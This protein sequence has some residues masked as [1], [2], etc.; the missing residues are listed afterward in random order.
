MATNFDLSS[1]YFSMSQTP[2]QVKKEM[3]P[4][5]FVQGALTK[6][7]DIFDRLTGR[8]WKPGSSL[9]TSELV[10]RLKS[11]MDAEAKTDAAGRKFVPHNIKLKM[12]WDKFSTDEEMSLK[13]LENELLTAAVDHIN[14]R[15]YYTYAP[16]SIG[17]KQDYFTEGVKLLV[18][19]DKGSG[20]ETERGVDV[21]VPDQNSAIAP[22]TIDTAPSVKQQ[23]TSRIRYQLNGVPR[24]A[25]ADLV[26]GKRL[27]IGRTKEND[28]AIDD[29]SISKYHAAIVLNGD[30]KVVVA[31]TGSTNGTFVADE[32]IAYGKAVEIGSGGAV[33]FGVVVVTI[34]IADV[35]VPEAE[36]QSEKPA[37]TEVYKVGEFEFAKKTSA[38]IPMTTDRSAKTEVILA[39]ATGN[40][41]S[42]LP[43]TEPAI[44][45][46]GAECGEK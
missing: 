14:D 4:D 13:S 6:I 29:Q 9:A 17:I 11:L 2:Q 8:G 15:H 21:M 38:A 5:W 16:I 42:E 26:E 41:R 20:T 35:I 30:G 37:E 1:L 23:R 28:I 39:E 44:K 40:D 19:F 7:G 34:E 12:Q 46:D 22:E 18:S 10:E 33:K 43:E 45:I 3:S 36:P 25:A 24:E 32:R 31:D 27:T